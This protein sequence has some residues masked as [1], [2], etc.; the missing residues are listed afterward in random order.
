MFL[1]LVSSTLSLIPLPKNYPGV[2]LESTDASVFFEIYVDPLCPDCQAFWPK[3]KKL[4]DIY[5]T[6]VQF[7]LHLLPLP[8]HS[9]AFELSRLIIA[10]NSIDPR[11][12][13]ILLDMLYGGDMNKFENNALYNKDTKS[14][15]QMIVQYGSNALGIDQNTLQAKYDDD[16]IR[17]KTISSASFAGSKGV[18]GTPTIFLNGVETQYGPETQ[19]EEIAADIDNLFM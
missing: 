8:Y 18:C 12:A 7:D 16:T 1:F 17:Q 11:K 19:I 2:I 14:A 6:Q 4:M 9:Y 13:V 3:L 5:P 10:V 15:A